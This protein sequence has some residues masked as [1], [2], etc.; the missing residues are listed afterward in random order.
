MA[1]FLRQQ[2][3]FVDG[4]QQPRTGQVDVGQRLADQP[5]VVVLGARAFA[6]DGL[7]ELFG[8][9]R[10]LGV[11]ERHGGVERVEF[12][13]ERLE[14]RVDGAGGAPLFGLGGRSFGGVV[15][16]VV[17]TLL[18]V[19]VE[20]LRVGRMMGVVDVMRMAK[21]FVVGGA[22]VG[23][24][25]NNGGKLVKFIFHVYLYLIVAH[26]IKISSYKLYS[27]FST[28]S[29]QIKIIIYKSIVVANKKTYTAR[30]YLTQYYNINYIQRS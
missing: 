6:R 11:D 8:A 14:V 21:V 19:V 13:V 10:D 28:P 20:L 9:L 29:A 22:V 27:I 15:V 26:K 16:V 7:L 30:D 2:R 1:P 3:T 23:S 18:L 17:V 24:E 4:G 12:T 25:T 5:I